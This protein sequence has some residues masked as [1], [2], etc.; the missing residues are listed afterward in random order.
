MKQR[1]VM[2]PITIYNFDFLTPNSNKFKL[3]LRGNF[4]VKREKPAELSRHF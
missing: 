4:L 2:L 1:F 3:L